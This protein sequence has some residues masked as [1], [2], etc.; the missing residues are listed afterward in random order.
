MITI[1]GEKIGVFS[2]TN[3][4]VTLKL[5]TA[6]EDSGGSGLDED[7]I[8]PAVE[9]TPLRRNTRTLSSPMLVRSRGRFLKQSS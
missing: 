6:I 3:V 5:Q 8:A 1:F 7:E 2:K 9:R 4:I